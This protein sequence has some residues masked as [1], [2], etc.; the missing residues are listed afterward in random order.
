[1]NG[2]KLDV[3]GKHF[4]EHPIGQNLE[5]PLGIDGLCVTDRQG[6]LVWFQPAENIPTFHH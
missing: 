6:R 5:S 2:S 1:M 4:A 3:I